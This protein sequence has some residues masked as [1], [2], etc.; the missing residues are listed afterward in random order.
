MG[1][2][3]AWLFAGVFA[4]GALATGRAEAQQEELSKQIREL[5]DSVNAVQKDLLEIK[6]LLARQVPPPSGIGAVIDY[7]KN[8]VK[9]E[10][11]AKLTLVEFS[12]YQ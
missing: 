10:Q 11:T 6:A 5:Q 8:P 1:R 7:G 12:D 9:G 3:V 4:V 2:N